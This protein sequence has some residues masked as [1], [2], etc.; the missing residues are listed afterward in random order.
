VALL[1]RSR[2]LLAILAI[3]TIL[4]LS[5]SSSALLGLVAL[6]ALGTVVTLF[7]AR[8]GMAARLKTLASVSFAVGAAWAAYQQV[9]VVRS[10]VAILVTTKSRSDSYLERTTATSNAFHTFFDFPWLGVG[11]GES[12]AYDLP[13]KML[14]NIG[15]IGTLAFVFM[16]WQT[17]RGLWAVS[18]GTSRTAEWTARQTV[19]RALLVTLGV[20][21]VL[22]WFTG[23][24]FESAYFWVLCGIAW[25]SFSVP[26]TNPQE[27]LTP[28]GQ[29]A[30]ASLPRLDGRR[31]NSDGGFG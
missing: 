18:P 16:M 8:S 23:F 13:A 26:L 4:L 31:S 12:T 5:A 2:D 11:L 17:A 22:G 6:L 20:Q 29:V 10:V 27:P 15:L 24:Y 28:R 9:P 3:L 30:M 7:T 19:S 1:G 25:A 21:L 14:S